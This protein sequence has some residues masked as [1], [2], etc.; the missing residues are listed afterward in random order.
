MESRGGWGPVC[1][2]SVCCVESRRSWCVSVGSRK[3]RLGKAVLAGLGLF[4]YGV[5]RWG[6]AR[7]FCFGLVRWFMVRSGRARSDLVRRL[8]RVLVGSCVLR[9]GKARLGVFR[10]LWNGEAW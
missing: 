5:M 3:V 8:R 4:L 10:R 1:F 2:G 6:W 7:R 9:L